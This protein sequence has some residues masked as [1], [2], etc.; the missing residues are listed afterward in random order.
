[1][2]E[3]SRIA[4]HYKAK[5]LRHTRIPT[6]HCEA[7]HNDRVWKNVKY[8]VKKYH[9]AI[10]FVITPVNYE[11]IQVEVG[12][13]PKPEWEEII[14]RRYT[15]L[16]SRQQELQPHVHL[17]LKPMFF[18]SKSWQEAKIKSAVS[19]ME[20]SLGVKP[21]KI[22]FGWW[23]FNRDSVK[24]SKSLGLDVVKRMDYFYTHDFDSS[25][26]RGE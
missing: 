9:R 10:W 4:N 5:L 26:F 12:A 1:M 3:L 24:I 22:A 19:W 2:S 6:I 14:T 13:P 16:K 17:R 18:S 8:W 21:D 20:S 25:F 23:S 11:F 7:I 15:W